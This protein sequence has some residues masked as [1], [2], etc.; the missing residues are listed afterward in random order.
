MS[1]FW[2]NL[3]PKFDNYMQLICRI[4]SVTTEAPGRIRSLSFP[5]FRARSSWRPTALWS[6][7][8]HT[9]TGFSH[10]MRSDGPDAGM[11]ICRRTLAPSSTLPSRCRAI[12]LAIAKTMARPWQSVLDT[13]RY[14]PMPTRFVEC[15]FHHLSWPDTGFLYSYST[16]L[17]NW[18]CFMV[19]YNI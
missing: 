2:R 7:R 11:L 1:I 3:M 17:L 19:F 12:R 4:S 8:S 9:R 14:W 18:L 6:R 10:S 5:A 15:I 13:M 16:I